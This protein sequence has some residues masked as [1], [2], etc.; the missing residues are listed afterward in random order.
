MIYA[1]FPVIAAMCYAVAFIFDEKVLEK[2][3]IPSVMVLSALIHL[4]VGIGTAIF[5]S[6]I[7]N[8]PISFS[9]WQDKITLMQFL[10]A[11][12]TTSLG[13]TLTLF[14]LQKTNAVYTSF[15][16]ISYPLFVVLFLAIFFG[17]RQFDLSVLIGG[18]LIFVGSFVLIY[19]QSKGAP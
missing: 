7:T 6:K 19:S 3:S 2:V 10:I 18:G 15:A 16:E 14:A 12:A 1:L 11:L 17:Q 9:V 8:T 13:I 4:P 5:L